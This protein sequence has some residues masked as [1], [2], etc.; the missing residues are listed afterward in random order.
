MQGL[1]E[2]Q[3][4]VQPF[5]KIV[6]AW[7]ETEQG[8]KV[9][10]KFPSKIGLKNCWDRVQ[11]TQNSLIK[12]KDSFESILKNQALGNYYML[13]MHLGRSDKILNSTQSMMINYLMIKKMALK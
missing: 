7:A 2:D 11:A 12:A 9:Q 1:A 4:R 3:L 10:A 8:E 5:R 13:D 6:D